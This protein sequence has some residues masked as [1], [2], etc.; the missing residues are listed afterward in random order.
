MRRFFIL[1]IALMS[2]YTITGCSTVTIIAPKD[3]KTG[4]PVKFTTEHPFTIKVDKNADVRTFWVKLNGKD[5]T[6][7]FGSVTAGETV[8]ANPPYFIT[9]ENNIIQAHASWKGGIRKGLTKPFAS[10]MVTRKFNV[11]ELTLVPVDDSIC[12]DHED[13]SCYIIRVPMGESVEIR[14]E[15]PE[16]PYGEL[17]VTLKENV[18][19]QRPI[20]AIEDQPPGESA[21]VVIPGHLRYVVATIKGIKIGSTHLEAFASTCA[22]GSIKIRVTE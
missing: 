6:N 5:I 4:T 8:T 11:M 16:T 17:G 9:P 19:N 2:M 22:R 12:L 10:T 21:R 13:L 20:F 18:L 14:V 7:M 1:I 3:S 15:L